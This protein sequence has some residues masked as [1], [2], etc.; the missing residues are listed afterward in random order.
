MV[1]IGRILENTYVEIAQYRVFSNFLPT[2]KGDAMTAKVY[3]DQTER[4]VYV[5]GT[6]GRYFVF[7]VCPNCGEEILEKETE[8]KTCKLQALWFIEKESLGKQVGDR[9]R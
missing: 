9:N 4:I 7:V 2:R 8:C 1:I 3:F 6:V 5:R